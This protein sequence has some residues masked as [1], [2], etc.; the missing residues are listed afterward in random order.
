ML[1]G[2]GILAATLRSFMPNRGPRPILPRSMAGAPAV[3][4]GRKDDR[5][6][7]LKRVG[8]QTALPF[9]PDAPEHVL[10]VIV[11]HR[12][13]IQNG[14]NGPVPLAWRF[15]Y[16]ALLSA[17]LSAYGGAVVLRPTVADL[18][19]FAGWKQF[20]PNRHIPKLAA[21]LRSLDDME[22]PY[23]GT[24]WR[25]VLARNIPR[26]SA[27]GLDTRIGLSVELPDDRRRGPQI[28]RQALRALALRSFPKYRG[29][30]GLSAYWDKYGQGQ[31]GA[32][33]LATN[34]NRERW[35][36]QTPEALRMMLFPDAVVASDEPRKINARTI[37]SHRA[38]AVRHV[39]A[40]QD[41]GLVEMIKT[42]GGWRIYRGRGK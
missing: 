12:G 37:R 11:S 15:W 19:R 30:L 26:A 38:R 39:E 21:A 10:P 42:A 22:I 28:D 5:L 41:A 18:V 20:N 4:V 40:M 13:A 14:G 24:G 25:P 23:R 7:R 31:G 9:V 2:G 27:I 29:L 17:P 8:A 35:P 3:H 33:A 32:D 6:P 1:E 34:P 16:E 36:V